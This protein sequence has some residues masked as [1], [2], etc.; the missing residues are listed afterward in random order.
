MYPAEVEK[1]VAYA[2]RLIRRE[3]A[4]ALIVPA[5]YL[6]VAVV[7]MVVAWYLGLAPSI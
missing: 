4:K 3:M 5:S 7:F 1:Q 6:A 2:R